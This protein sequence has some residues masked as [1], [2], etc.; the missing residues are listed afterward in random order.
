[1]CRTGG[2]VVCILRCDEHD[3]IV[4]SPAM[5]DV[6]D[7]AKLI[8]SDLRDR[9]IL[10]L[11]LGA[12]RRNNQLEMGLGVDIDSPQ[13]GLDF[14]DSVDRYIF[15]L[16]HRVELEALGPVDA[17]ARRGCD[18]VHNNISARRGV[19]FKKQTVR[20]V[21]TQCG[22]RQSV[23]LEKRG[24]IGENTKLL[25][26][27]ENFVNVRRVRA[28]RKLEGSPEGSGIRRETVLAR[29]KLSFIETRVCGP[30]DLLRLDVFIDESLHLAA[31]AE[32]LPV[33]DIFSGKFS[34]AASRRKSVNGTT[35]SV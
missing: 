26:R 30:A 10:V 3:G 33:N 19:L 32:E 12:V 16:D 6:M 18:D 7:D 22:D 27:S 1:M 17:R 20:V 23:H 5:D 25:R 4:E 9:G 8:E 29:R 35:K 28:G 15:D 13:G 2:H 14:I 34:V 24:V 11:L 31:V 21:R